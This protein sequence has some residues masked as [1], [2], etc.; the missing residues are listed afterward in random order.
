MRTPVIKTINRWPRD[1]SG[2]GRLVAAMYT[3]LGAGHFPIIHPPSAL[4]RTP[5]PNETLIESGI[6][7][8]VQAPPK[9][10]KMAISWARIFIP[11]N[12]ELGVA[13]K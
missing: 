6:R 4:K 13:I 8:L 12:Y 11:Q 1:V 9:I 3:G 10:N 5:T 7:A 2:A